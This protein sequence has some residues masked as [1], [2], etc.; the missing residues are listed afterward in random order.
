[1]AKDL[2]IGNSCINARSETVAEKPAFRNDWR[3]G[4]RCLISATGFY[5][6]KGCDADAAVP[7]QAVFRA[8]FEYAYP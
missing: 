1:V 6:W 5:E 4:R 2:K 8:A 3:A 7:D